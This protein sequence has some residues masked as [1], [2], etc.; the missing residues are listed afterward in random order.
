VPPDEERD[1]EAHIERWLDEV[2]I[3][4]DLCPFA[5]SP[6]RR[7]QIHIAVHD[8]SSPGDALYAT[9]SEIDA[10]LALPPDERATTLVALP[11]ALADFERYLDVAAALEDYLA[12]AD[13]EGTLQVATF[14]PDYR[15]AGAP[16]D[17]PSNYTNRAPYPIFHILREDDVSEAIARHPDVD[18]IPERNIALFEELGADRIAQIWRS[19]EVTDS[20]LPPTA[21][22]AMFVEIH[23]QDDASY[24]LNTDHVVTL[25]W[26]E[27]DW[28]ATL[29][30]ETPGGQRTEQW[31]WESRSYNADTEEWET[32][33]V[34]E[35]RDRWARTRDELEAFFDARRRGGAR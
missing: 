22:D 15:F 16:P 33:A 12:E 26:E 18:A 21:E 23:P 6:R 2:V 4:L 28:E 32:H 25:R 9:A 3:G 34:E 27:G 30:Y 29:T 35:V 1:I 19:L 14:H 7:G 24:F 8:A 13:L 20:P 5:A 10:L 31:D 11:R 17:A